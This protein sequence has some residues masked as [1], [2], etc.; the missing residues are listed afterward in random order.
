MK[1][2]A[3]ISLL[4]LFSCINAFAQEPLQPSRDDLNATTESMSHQHHH[5]MGPHMHMSALR[6]PQ[7]GDQEK[8][9]QVADK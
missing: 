6:D 9:Q 4:A 8:A 2:I 1:K 3:T 7:P 5:Q